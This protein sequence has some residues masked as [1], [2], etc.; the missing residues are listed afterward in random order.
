MMLTLPPPCSTSTAEQPFWLRLI[1]EPYAAQ[2][3]RE[4]LVDLDVVP[5][6]RLSDLQLLV[7]EL[8]ANSVI[9]AELRPTD[10]IE[11]RIARS[12]GAL[13]VDVVDGGPGFVPPPPPTDP[14]AES[15]RGLALVAT[16]SDRWGVA[17]D[18]V[19]RV[20]FEIDLD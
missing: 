4:A 19:T 5:G 12:D 18:G 3:A 8:V 1:P 11:V 7:T 14:F 15:G 17:C 16:V 6:D 2:A 20:W 10:P 13:R 9:H